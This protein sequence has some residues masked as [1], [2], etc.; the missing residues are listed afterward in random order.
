[1]TIVTKLSI[2]GIYGALVTP[3]HILQSPG[4]NTFE[5]IFFISI[6]AVYIVINEIPL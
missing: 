1:M 6:S 3:L 4:K 5:S 2:L